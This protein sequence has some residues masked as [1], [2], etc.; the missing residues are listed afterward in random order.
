MGLCPRLE[1][2]YP[3]IF[4]SH[5]VHP[6]HSRQCWY[7]WMMAWISFFLGCERK[8]IKDFKEILYWTINSMRTETKSVLFFR[9]T[10][11]PSLAQRYLTKLINYTACVFFNTIS[12]RMN[13]IPSIILQ[14]FIF[15]KFFFQATKSLCC[16][17]R[18]FP[19]G[20]YWFIYLQ[21]LTIAWQIA[22]VTEHRGRVIGHCF[23]IYWWPPTA[24]TL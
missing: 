19:Q 10:P 9:I 8:D 24:V 3:S 11:A 13:T 14:K 20:L 23:K 1:I 7:V 18:T 5:H 15:P 2:S 4:I 22:S 17:L 6:L 16:R 21:S 12:G